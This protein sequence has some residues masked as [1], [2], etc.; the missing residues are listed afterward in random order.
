MM[1]KQQIVGVYAGLS[2]KK[3]IRFILEHY[4]DFESYRS[5][6]K[7]CIISIMIAI[8]EGRRNRDDDLGVRVQTSGGNSDT[9]Y[10]K[11]LERLSVDDCF[12]FLTVTR[13]MFPDP[14]E[15]NLISTAI[16]EWD[17]MKRE[18]DELNSCMNFLLKENE[19]QM[20]LSFINKNKK[21]KDIAYDCSIE[22]DSAK[23]KVYR[24]KRKLLDGATPWFKEYNIKIP[25]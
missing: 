7:E 4:K 5:S 23:K 14:Y 3:R 9:T 6:Y 19:K 1:A 10:Y 20:L 15:H 16:F 11:A 12:R 17:L 25:A 21:L 22:L 18:Y 8:N 13:D 24:I 2:V